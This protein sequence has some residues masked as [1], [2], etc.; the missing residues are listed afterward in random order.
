MQISVPLMPQSLRTAH[1]FSQRKS[2][3]IAHLFEVAHHALRWLVCSTFSGCETTNSC[4]MPTVQC[5]PHCLCDPVVLCRLFSCVTYS[6]RFTLSRNKTNN[7]TCTAAHG[8]QE[9]ACIDINV[10][11]S[12]HDIEQHK[13]ENAQTVQPSS[14]RMQK[15]LSRD[16]VYPRVHVATSPSRD[17]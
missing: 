16:C 3:R 15:H 2:L 17:Y 1:H 8:L 14:G 9:D 10:L 12:L 11:V 7:V 5:L 6:V 13:L 4:G